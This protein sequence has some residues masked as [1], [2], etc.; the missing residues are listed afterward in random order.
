MRH[1]LAESYAGSDFE[2]SLTVMGRAEVDNVIQQLMADDSSVKPTMMLASPYKRT[3]QTAQIAHRRLGL[4]LPFETEDMLVHTAS[5]K[6]LG[7]YLLACD[8][9]NLIIVSHMPIVACLCRYLSSSLSV[10][11]FKTAQIVKLTIQEG[12]ATIDKSYLPQT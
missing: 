9:D 6:V 10:M 5:E 7:D 3:Q 8:L 2:R 4:T 1:G 12:T 11:S